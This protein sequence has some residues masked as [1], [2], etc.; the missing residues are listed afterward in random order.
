MDLLNGLRA[1]NWM[2]LRSWLDMGSRSE[3]VP[4]TGRR[5]RPSAEL[6]DRLREGKSELRRSRE[7]LSVPEKIRQI[8]ELQRLH[9]PLLSKQRTLEPWERPWE[10]EP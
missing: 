9:F 1:L 3:K 8:L 6:L 7:Q 4:G 5:P 10:L 2:R